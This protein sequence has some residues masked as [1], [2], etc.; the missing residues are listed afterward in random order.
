MDGSGCVFFLAF[1]LVFAAKFVERFLNHIAIDVV[2]ALNVTEQETAIADD[3]D[4]ARNAL[5]HMKK[6][7]PGLGRK[8]DIDLS[9]R[10]LEAVADVFIDFLFRKR[11]DVM[12][13][14]DSLIELFEFRQRECLAKLGLADD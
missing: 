6:K 5:G 2:T 14:G 10:D 7:P 13:D 9:A 4:A 8:L 1:L 12:A 11:S 3:I